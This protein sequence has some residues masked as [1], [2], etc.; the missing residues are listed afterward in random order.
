MEPNGKPDISSVTGHKT[1]GNGCLR[2]GGLLLP[3]YYQDIHDDTGQI[4][5]MALR[6]AVCGEVIDPVIL[7]NRRVPAPNL[8][9]GTKKRV[10]SQRIVPKQSTLE[11]PSEISDDEKCADTE[12]E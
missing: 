9:Q 11:R 8:Y 6:C 7:K 5:F 1:D 10:Y 12:N 2:C 4:D 3:T